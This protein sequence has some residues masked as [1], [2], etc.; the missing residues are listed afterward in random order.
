MPIYSSHLFIRVVFM[1]KVYGVFFE[2]NSIQQYILAGGRLRDIVG[3]SYLIDSLGGK[4]LDEV[5][6]RLGLSGQASDPTKS[7]RFPR[8]AAGAIYALFAA[9]AEATNFAALWSLVVRTHCPSLSFNQ[10]MA[11]GDNDFSVLQAGTAALAHARAYPVADFPPATPVTERAPRTGRAKIGDT[12]VRGGTTREAV[13][14]ALASR[15]KIKEQAI[16]FMD[17]RVLTGERRLALHTDRNLKVVFPRDLEFEEADVRGDSPRRWEFP[18]KP[19]SRYLAMIHADGNGFGQILLKVIEAAS[20]EAANRTGDSNGTTAYGEFL[21]ELS[22]AV[23]TCTTQAVQHAIKTILLAHGAPANAGNNETFWRLPARPIVIAGDDLTMLV[24]ADLALAFT[25]QFIGKFEVLTK[26]KF[27]E[28]R[29]DSRFDAF[30]E[31]LPES[32]LTACAGIAFAR[33]NQP[34]AMLH[35]VAEHLCGEAKQQVKGLARNALTGAN[36]KGVYQIAGSAI[37]WRRITESLLGNET[38][39]KLDGT[40]VFP[41]MGALSV[42]AVNN[43]LPTVH[44]LEDLL[45]SLKPSTTGAD[46][47]ATGRDDPLS[48]GPLRRILSTV[49]MQPQD[50]S[51]DYQRWKSLAT[52]S[53]ATPAQQGAPHRQITRFSEALAVLAKPTRGGYAW[54]MLPAIAWPASN[55][56]SSA[57]VEARLVLQELVD[58]LAIGHLPLSSFTT[59]PATHTQREETP[60]E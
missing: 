23:A 57:P 10:T 18:F 31:L 3:A 37:A 45:A 17:N 6:K 7:I 59:P 47:S 50:A 40:E 48:K 12:P 38:P 26:A 14:A 4:V 34:F 53:I 32:G 39:T 43:G 30:A 16:L 19:D 44:A 13:D 5:C 2:A 24:R 46:D 25:C 9:E 15:R 11:S 1:P 56:A 21:P 28:L 27:E 20:D 58:L 22:N 42:G 55:N 52:G 29:N 36:G 35:E 41:R 51:I 49:F 60:D 8:R 33:N 54:D